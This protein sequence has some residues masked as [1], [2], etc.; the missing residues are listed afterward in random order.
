MISR[1]FEFTIAPYGDTVRVLFGPAAE[2]VA[3]LKRRGCE[4]TLDDATGY[5][6][7]PTDPTAPESPIL[8]WVADETD[9]ATIAHELTHVTFS[10]LHRA[11]V[12]ISFEN[13]E[14]AAYL[15]GYLFERVLKRLAKPARVRKAKQKAKIPNAS[16]PKTPEAAAKVAEP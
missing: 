7:T 8:M 12:P 4:T 3:W 11:G 13:E 6:H 9:M 15:L 5:T 1:Q 16:A 14:A 2:G 10:I